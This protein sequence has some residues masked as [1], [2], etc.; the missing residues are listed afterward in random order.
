[1]K[2][3]HV[4]CRLSGGGV[5]QYL[6]QL[7]DELEERGHENLFLLGDVS[8][9]ESA[10]PANVKPFFIEQVTQLACKDANKKLRLVRDIISKEKP[11]LI[12]IHQ[13]LNSSLIELL[14]KERPT[15]RFVHDFKLVC[16]DGKKILN[17]DNNVCPFPLGYHCQIHAYQYKCMP[18]NPLIGLPLIH[19]AKRIAQIHR[20]HSHM[21]VASKFMKYVLLYNGFAEKRIQVIPHFTS[22][23]ETKI[24]NPSTAGP[25]ILALG[26]I[27]KN[28]GFHILLRAFA[29]INNMAHI[30]IAGD[31]PAINELKSI[32]EDLGISSKVTFAGHVPHD[33]LDG[34]YQKCSLV[35]VPSVWPEPFGLVGIEAMSYRKPVVAFDVGGISEWLKHGET[36]FLVRPG[37]EEAL[38]EKIKLLLNNPD[39]SEQF[40]KKGRETVKKRFLT[41]QHL[42][43]LLTLFKTL[44]N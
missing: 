33:K 17:S 20:E 12:F 40:G 28:K 11:D 26:R 5:E 8:D 44:A 1:M 27:V 6:S 32:S 31:G 15:V 29:N 34:L 25:I 42:N 35:V 37:D 30:V 21:V 13:V 22:L 14:T 19:N 10:F 43:S 3:L 9:S 24:E 16:P 41:E 36:G 39:M 7:F 4:N 38:A 2:V 23:P 18:R